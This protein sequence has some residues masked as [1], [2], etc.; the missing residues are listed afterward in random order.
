MSRGIL[1]TKDF[2]KEI[3]FKRNDGHIVI[4]AKINGQKGLFYFDS[5]CLVLK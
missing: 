5:D 4:E 3:P 2:V 1:I